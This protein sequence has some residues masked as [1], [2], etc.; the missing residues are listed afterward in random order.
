[1]KLYAMHKN[2]AG[3]AAV[4]ALLG[5]VLKTEYGVISPEIR[6]TKYG[7]PYFPHENLFFSLSHSKNYVLCAISNSEIGA[8]I[9]EP[10]PFSPALEKRLCSGKELL[11]FSFLELWVLKESAIKLQGRLNLPYNKINF[12]REKSGIFCPAYGARAALYGLN[13]AYVGVCSYN[14]TFPGGV[15]FIEGV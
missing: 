5:H 11:D 10:R 15:E 1:M 13:G 12:R 2:N 14:E 4:Y 8:D 6:K 3:T 7:K 9:E